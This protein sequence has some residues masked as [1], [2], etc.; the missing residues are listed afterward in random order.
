MSARGVSFA[1]LQVGWRGQTD[2]SGISSNPTP[3]DVVAMFML[4]MTSQQEVKA[5]Q[6]EVK[7]QVI[8]FTHDQQNVNAHQDQINDE[9]QQQICDVGVELEP[10]DSLQPEPVFNSNLPCHLWPIFS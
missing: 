6:L 9:V 10:I 2:G 1:S 3:P 5:S 7:A 8:Q 4:L